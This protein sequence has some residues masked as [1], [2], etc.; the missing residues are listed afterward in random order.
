MESQSIPSRFSSV[1]FCIIMLAA[2]SGCTPLSWTTSLKSFS[3]GDMSSWAAS[4]SFFTIEPR[5]FFSASRFGALFF[6]A[7]SI[8]LVTNMGRV[9]VSGYILDPPGS[10]LRNLEVQSSPGF[11]PLVSFGTPL[12]AW[13]ALHSACSMDFHAFC[14]W[15]RYY[16]ESILRANVQL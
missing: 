3:L 5:P 10:G 2:N 1:N 9:S 11:A 4:A 14:F 6:A 15:P 7:F 8:S 12:S 16:H 13:S